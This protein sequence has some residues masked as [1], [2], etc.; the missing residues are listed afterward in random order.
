M[1]Y[2]K[3]IIDAME[4]RLLRSTCYD[5]YLAYK[6]FYRGLSESNADSIG[7]Y[8]MY[9]VSFSVEYYNIAPVD[10]ALIALKIECNGHNV[11]FLH[12]LKLEKKD[13][14]MDTVKNLVINFTPSDTAVT[15][16]IY[17]AIASFRK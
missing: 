7:C 5:L 8:V 13:K 17:N 14:I 6:K 11:R 15:K 10:L 9:I 12:H 3:E 2:T 16:K 1:T 4:F